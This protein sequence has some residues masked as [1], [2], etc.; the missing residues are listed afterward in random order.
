MIHTL[1]GR[2]HV[3]LIA[4]GVVTLGSVVFP[5][6]G[7]ELE[8]TSA[9]DS[10]SKKER[11]LHSPKRRTS[12]VSVTSQ[13]HITLATFVVRS[14]RTP[15]L[16]GLTFT[17]TSSGLSRSRVSHSRGG[18]DTLTADGSST[19]PATDTGGAV[20]GLVGTTLRDAFAGTVE[21]LAVVVAFTS[22]VVVG[23]FGL[24]SRAAAFLRE[25][26]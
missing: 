13:L 19:G 8:L 3:L 9:R 15:S 16:G 7:D 20:P 5:T 23:I 2:A 10:R 25:A 4:A 11:S 17:D 18:T 22:T 21:G 26:R 6:V 14:R 1:T 24:T 12:T